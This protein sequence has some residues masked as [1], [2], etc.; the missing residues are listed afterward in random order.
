MLF[1]RVHI[2]PFRWRKPPVDAERSAPAVW[3]PNKSTSYLWLGLAC[4]L[5]AN[6]W[7]GATLQSNFEIDQL[8][9][10]ELYLRNDAARYFTDLDAFE[11]R[12]NHMADTLEV[13]PAWIMAVFHTESK[14]NPRVINYR[15]SGATGLI[16]F[17]R[18]ALQDLNKRLGTRY[19]M[20]DLVKMDP[21]QQLDL[22]E[23]YFFQQME[24][25]GPYESLT[26]LYLSV[27]FPR[28][29]G[30]SLDYVM[31]WSPTL[32]YR[33]NNGLDENRDGRV[34]IRDIDLR[35]KRLHPIAYRHRY[36]KS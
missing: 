12:L 31:F 30:H 8:L 23:A 6:L 9:S 7:M 21:I 19:A 18:P 26:D 32:K 10:D 1:P 33:Q 24:R 11:A 36:R 5:G 34:S 15:G 17:M 35:M 3:R 20:S 27:L 2:L 13:P 16:Q 29:R 25:A 22:V 4:L 28:A 14:F